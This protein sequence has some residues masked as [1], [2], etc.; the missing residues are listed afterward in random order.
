MKVYSMKRF[1]M[2]VIL[3]KATLDEDEDEDDMDEDLYRK[4]ILTKMTLMTID[5]SREKNRTIFLKGLRLSEKQFSTV[6]L[7]LSENPSS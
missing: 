4:T 1:Q 3:M 2:M 5:P 6:F 7:C